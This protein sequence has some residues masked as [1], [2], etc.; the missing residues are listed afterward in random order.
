M[1][2]AEQVLRENCNSR[3]KE[4]EREREREKQKLKPKKQKILNY[5]K[6]SKM[7]L[8]HEYTSEFLVFTLAVLAFAIAEN[9]YFCWKTTQK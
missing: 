3:E 9:T 7:H 2:S 6:K 4:R 1:S 5:P 8:K